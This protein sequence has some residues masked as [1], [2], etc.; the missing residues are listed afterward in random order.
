MVVYIY[1]KISIIVT[2]AAKIV[3]KMKNIQGQQI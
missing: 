3:V 2:I 1:S